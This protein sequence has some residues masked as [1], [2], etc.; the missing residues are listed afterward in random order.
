MLDVVKNIHAKEIKNL[1]DC[2]FFS[3]TYNP[4]HRGH[5]NVYMHAISCAGE[6]VIFERCNSPYDKKEAEWNSQLFDDLGLSIIQT[7]ARSFVDKYLRYGFWNFIIGFDTFERIHNP[8]YYC[9][10]KDYMHMM[11]D[12]HLYECSFKVYPRTKRQTKEI[13]DTYDCTDNF[14]FVRDFE[15]IEISSTEIRNGDGP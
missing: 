7:Q 5:I 1:K 11:L 13:F 3:G 14:V 15:P 2:L 8:K 6:D 12:T 4:L 9:G 10:S